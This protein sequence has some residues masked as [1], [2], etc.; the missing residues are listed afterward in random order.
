MLY[1]NSDIDLYP[2][3]VHCTINFHY[4]AHIFGFPNW[5]L[6]INLQLLQT[7]VWVDMCR[8]TRC[9][10]SMFI[11]YSMLVDLYVGSGCQ[12]FN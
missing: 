7:T 8:S 11:M 4:E 10:P 1:T 12:V 5:F 2:E 9:Q 3:P 6:Y